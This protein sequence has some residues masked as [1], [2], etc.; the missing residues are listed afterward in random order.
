V[1]HR[2]VLLPIAVFALVLAACGGGQAETCDELAEE[3]VNLMQELIDDVEKEVGNVSVEE[4]IATGEA[5]PSV[6]GFEE[7]AAK[8]DDRAAE[9]GCTQTEVQNGVAARANQLEANTPI[10]Q[11]LIEAVRDGGL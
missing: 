9:L 6:E 10:G 1:L 2:T 4:L 3:T 5:L 8:I 11:F 7:D